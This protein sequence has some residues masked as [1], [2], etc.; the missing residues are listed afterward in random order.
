MVG[1]YNMGDVR[2]YDCHQN[3]ILAFQYL[4]CLCCCFLLLLLF[5]QCSYTKVIWEPDP[6]KGGRFYL[7]I[8]WS[9]PLAHS[10]PSLVSLQ[11]AS[12]AQLCI[13]QHD[14]WINPADVSMNYTLPWMSLIFCSFCSC[15]PLNCASYSAVRDL[16]VNITPF[17]SNND[18]CTFQVVHFGDVFRNGL[19][20]LLL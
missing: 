20:L 14:V 15:A 10:S 6:Y 8:P 1:S 2:D 13:S 9:F 7:P 16:I 5:I 12:G 4:E 3:T 19:F 11:A 17:L 18:N